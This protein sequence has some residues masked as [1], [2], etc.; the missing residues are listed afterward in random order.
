MLNFII[1]L[2]FL[3]FHCNI[4]GAFSSL[5]VRLKSHNIFRKMLFHKNSQQHQYS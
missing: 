4:F 5:P 3:K 2:P 1:A